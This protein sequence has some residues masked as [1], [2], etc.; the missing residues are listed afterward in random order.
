MRG[1]L[2]EPSTYAGLAAVVA[3]VGQIAQW[4]QASVV[5]EAITQA[6]PQVISGNWLGGIMSIFG[7]AAIF[8]REGKQ[9]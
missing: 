4:N 6:A 1:L 5:A 7:L 9:K 2:K 8:L 3:G